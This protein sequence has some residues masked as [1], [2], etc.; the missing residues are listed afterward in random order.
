MDTYMD[1]SLASP[2]AMIEGWFS[3]YLFK[4]SAATLRCKLSGQKAWN[5]LG[6]R[7]GPAP[8]FHIRGP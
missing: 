3:I 8:Y 6:D 7:P 2:G 5:C 4:A 1:T